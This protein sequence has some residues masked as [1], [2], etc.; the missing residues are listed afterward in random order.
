MRA[1]KIQILLQVSVELFEVKKTSKAF[2]S[3]DTCIELDFFFDFFR[4]SSNCPFELLNFFSY[5]KNIDKCL[6]ASS[7]KSTDNEMYFN[8]VFN[9]D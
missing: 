4:A 3:L 6:F 9:L 7:M 5:F 2:L 8:I 1:L